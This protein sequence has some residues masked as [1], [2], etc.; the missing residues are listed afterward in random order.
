MLTE[1]IPLKQFKANSRDIQEDDGKISGYNINW[2]S[3]DSRKFS[4][5]MSEWIGKYKNADEFIKD[6]G[7][8]GEITKDNLSELVAETKIPSKEL[9]N[10]LSTRVPSDVCSR[11][12]LQNRW[13]HSLG[14]ENK[15]QI[16]ISDEVIKKERSRVI[17]VIASSDESKENSH[18]VE[19]LTENINEVAARY[20][21]PVDVEKSIAGIA[22]ILELSVAQ[23]KGID[24][25]PPNIIEEKAEKLAGLFLREDGNFDSA[26]SEARDAWSGI[27]TNNNTPLYSQIIRYLRHSSG[28]TQKEFAKASGVL[29]LNLFNLERGFTIEKDATND[30]I[31]KNF[32]LTEED[33]KIISASYKEYKDFVI[34]KF[35]KQS[36]PIIERFSKYGLTK[37]KYLEATIYQP[38]IFYQR[39]EHII[40]NIETVQKHFENN[41]VTLQNYLKAVLKQPQLFL[42]S[43]ETIISNIETVYNH[44]KDRGFKLDD[45]LK[46]ALSSPR[47]FSKDPQPLIEHIDLIID[48]Y[49]KELFYP[50]G[51]R[52]SKFDLPKPD[53]NDLSPVF[54]FITHSSAVTNSTNDLKTRY[55]ASALDKYATGKTPSTKNLRNTKAKV[56]TKLLAYLNEED[57]GK[58]TPAS[59]VRAELFKKKKPIEGKA[60][61]E[62][63]IW[64]TQVKKP[65]DRENFSHTP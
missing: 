22:K 35:Q 13:K 62:E 65:T 10:Y 63:V 1:T 47:L 44:Y 29:Y 6:I 21:K 33:K 7:L 50:K 4:D 46:R 56:M 2:F 25:I 24:K 49:Q 12:K 16:T 55:L 48:M 60:P 53:P 27:K 3:H 11:L 31:F 39:P 40:S 15:I 59:F 18:F 42:Q 30:K 64:A 34:Q 37:E 43:P 8:S 45:Y 5:V 14:S 51:A 28:M 38:H 57:I 19:F 20:K 58:E 26:V 54:N 17:K 32:N 9:T 61:E 41:G 52:P 36:A 23:L